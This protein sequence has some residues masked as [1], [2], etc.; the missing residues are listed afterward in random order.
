MSLSVDYIKMDEDTVQRRETV[1]RKTNLPISRK[2]GRIYDKLSY[3]HNRSE[4]E[5]FMEVGQGPN[6]GC[7]ANE[8]KKLLSLPQDRM[9]PL[10]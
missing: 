4:T 2:D 3:Y 8:K 10:I 9:F 7:S 1:T 6:W 5:I